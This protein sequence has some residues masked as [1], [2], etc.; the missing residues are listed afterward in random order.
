V[1]EAGSAAAKGQVAARQSCCSATPQ[2]P[3]DVTPG[4]LQ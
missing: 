1:A 2:T 3:S 4:N